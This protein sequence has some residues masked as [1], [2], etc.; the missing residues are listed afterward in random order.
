MKLKL[1][2]VVTLIRLL[3]LAAAVTGLGAFIHTKL[4]AADTNSTPAQAQKSEKD[5]KDGHED[6]DGPED[7]EGEPD[8]D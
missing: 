5:D 3:A 2:K 1:L 8:D 6:K 7:N 4:Q